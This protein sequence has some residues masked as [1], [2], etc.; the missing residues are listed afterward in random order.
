MTL[1]LATHD[2]HVAARAPR[3]LDLLD[4]Q[5]VSNGS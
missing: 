4:G 2:A 1:L 3:V 5:I